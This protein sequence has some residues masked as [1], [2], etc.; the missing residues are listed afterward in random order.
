MLW[1]RRALVLLRVEQLDGLP[2]TANRVS[3]V[4]GGLVLCRVEAVCML[5][6]ERAVAARGGTADGLPATANG[7]SGVGGWF[8]VL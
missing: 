2:A 6:G 3:R 5:W 7:V 1:G 4:G 8:G